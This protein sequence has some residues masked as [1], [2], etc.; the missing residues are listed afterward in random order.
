MIRRPPR[1]TLFP[2]TTLFRSFD[3][4]AGDGVAFMEIRVVA[5]SG[6]VSVVISCNGQHSGSS[7]SFYLTFGRHLAP[8]FYYFAH[9]T[10]GGSGER[11]GGEECRYRWAADHLKK[12][13][14]KL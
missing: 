5:H 8:G 10:A 13:K 14:K 6:A 7:F 3:R 1:S 2:Y 12:K 4:A 9:L 11:R